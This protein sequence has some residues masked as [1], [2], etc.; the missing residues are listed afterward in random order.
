MET[1]ETPVAAF[2][3]HDGQHTGRFV[4]TQE[5]LPSDIEKAL[6]FFGASLEVRQRVSMV[7]N[8]SPSIAE[9]IRFEEIEE[10]VR[11]VVFGAIPIS[12]V[13]KKLQS[14]EFDE[15]G[16]MMKVKGRGH[17]AARTLR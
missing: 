10:G 1:S 9:G 16:V 13:D 17:W 3:A 2:C 5:R 7:L 14:L 6:V 15:Q 12:Y 11:T 4:T 8:K